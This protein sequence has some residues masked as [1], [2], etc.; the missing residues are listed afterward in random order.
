VNRRA[1]R[2]SPCR[3]GPEDPE[4]GQGR[5]RPDIEHESLF[6]RVD[7]C[8]IADADRPRHMAQEPGSNEDRHLRVDVDVQPV[9]HLDEI[10]VLEN[11]GAIR[12]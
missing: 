11:I 3:S 7:V 12:S 6:R 4:S 2:R 9:D 8:K 1:G 5:S 10:E